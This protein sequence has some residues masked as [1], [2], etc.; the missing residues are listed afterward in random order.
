MKE[1][2][3]RIF[4][5]CKRPRKKNLTTVKGKTAKNGE[6]HGNMVN[7]NRHRSEQRQRST[8]HRV[9]SKTKD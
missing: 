7:L 5:L 8:K 2:Y 9:K 1:N 4:T 6:Y 3:Q